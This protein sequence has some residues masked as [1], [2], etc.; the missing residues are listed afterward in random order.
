MTT[1]TSESMSA[2]SEDSEEPNS[3][4]DL[5]DPPLSDLSTEE[6]WNYFI[7]TVQRLVHQ[8]FTFEEVCDMIRNKRPLLSYISS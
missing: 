7:E 6:L 2:S 8:G 4:A 1:S 3:S 5:S